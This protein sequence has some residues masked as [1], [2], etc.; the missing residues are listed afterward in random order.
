MNSVNRFI[1]GALLSLSLVNL[2][3]SA[4]ET[5]WPKNRLLQC[6]LFLLVARL[7]Y[8]HVL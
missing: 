7:M 2:A 4:P 3:F 5:D 1:T 6:S 8:L